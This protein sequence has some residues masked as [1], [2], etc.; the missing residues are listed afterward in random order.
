MN[1][2]IIE[3]L[4]NLGIKWKKTNSNNIVISCPFHEEKTPSCSIN[5]NKQVFFCFG[6]HEG[7]NI[8]KL[9]NKINPY[10]YP[11]NQTFE[12]KKEIPDEIKCNN[13]LASFFN[14]AITDFRDKFKVIEKYVKRGLTPEV[15]EYFNIGYAPDTVD[16]KE[17]LIARGE[18]ENDWKIEKNTWQGNNVLNDRDELCFKGRIT[19]P[20]YDIYGNVVGF[21]GRATDDSPYKYINS[22]E[23]KN[24]KKGSVLFNLF[25][26]KR[27]IIQQKRV[28]I[29]EGPFDCV[30]YHLAG[31]KNV[32]SPLTC[33][34]SQNQLNLI[35]N[36]CGKDVEFVVAFDND[37]AGKTGIK[38]CF[39]LFKK[40]SIWNYGT[41]KYHSN[42]KDGGEYIEKNQLDKLIS[43]VSKPLSLGEYYALEYLNEDESK[44]K[45]KAINAFVTLISTMPDFVAQQELKTFNKTIKDESNF[46]TE[47]YLKKKQDTEILKYIFF[48]IKNDDAKKQEFEKVL[49]FLT[50][51]ER[52]S[53]DSIESYN[54]EKYSNDFKFWFLLGHFIKARVKNNLK[55]TD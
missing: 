45:S 24:F 21:T 7:G 20:I 55:G 9:L 46:A 22:K 29:V 30:A 53:Y 16:Y 2:D 10:K 14:V 28:Y 23:S 17:M 39:E 13:F 4:T 18:R 32:V 6:C 37:Q 12:N 11:L 43:L 31:I 36:T 41:I 54:L 52:T 50:P 1:I 44:I 33:S 49:N 51:I 48:Q 5:I 3:E 19:F 40:N 38:N 8:L 34:L 35:M 25:R 15:I 26:A 47:L 27:D 42:F